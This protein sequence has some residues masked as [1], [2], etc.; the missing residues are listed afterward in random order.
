MVLSKQN[1]L[2]TTTIESW[3]SKSQSLTPRGMG[4]LVNDAVF[5]GHA[6]NIFLF[7][8]CPKWKKTHK[9]C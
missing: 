2:L 7:W 5:S 4:L 1:V 6:E 8:I 9:Y 3:N